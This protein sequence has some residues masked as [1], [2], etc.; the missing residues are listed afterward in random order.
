MPIYTMGLDK[1]NFPRILTTPWGKESIIPTT[2][3]RGTSPLVTMGSTEVHYLNS[4]D[5]GEQPWSNI[6][7]PATI[8][9]T[10]PEYR[11]PGTTGSFY[12]PHTV[13]S[14]NF[15]WL[16]LGVSLLGAPGTGFLCPFTSWGSIR[17]IFP[18]Y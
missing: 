2:R 8:K 14:L 12:N 10:F 6:W 1:T 9:R 17:R 18:E 13:P 11:G 15:A 7:P 3:T 5:N 16:S 4:N